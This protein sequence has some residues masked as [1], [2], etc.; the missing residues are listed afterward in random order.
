MPRPKPAGDGRPA[1][2][3]RCFTIQS[4]CRSSFK[5]PSVAAMIFIAATF[6]TGCGLFHEYRPMHV[7]VRDAETKQPLAGVEVRGWYMTMMD[8]F[9]PNTPH[10]TTDKDG[11]V[12]LQI[13]PDRLF[14]LRV[15]ED[16]YLLAD[17]D[18]T[19]EY[20][21]KLPRKGDPDD[22]PGR[23]DFVFDLKPEEHPTFILIIPDNYRGLVKVC[24]EPTETVKVE[25]RRNYEIPVGVDG[26]AVV[27]MPEALCRPAAIRWVTAAREKSGKRV[28]RNLDMNSRQIGLWPLRKTDDIEVYFVGTA[29]KWEKLQ[30]QYD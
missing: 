30:R 2:T 19:Q 29:A 21:K 20:F 13:G 11:L 26:L 18:A 1:I 4:A 8:V 9:G 23:I 28:E 10:G 12:T 27:R 6:S 3:P 16:G 24:Y 14:V 7:L 5:P 17:T 15:I 25:R 22:L